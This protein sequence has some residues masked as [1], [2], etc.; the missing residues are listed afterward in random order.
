M[1]ALSADINA[2]DVGWIQVTLSGPAANDLTESQIEALLNVAPNLQQPPAGYLWRFKSDPPGK[3]RDLTLT[4]PSRAD[5]V[6]VPVY[7]ESKPIPS[8]YVGQ[9]A[10]AYLSQGIDNFT[11]KD[12]DAF[13]RQIV[14]GIRIAE[15]PIPE[16]LYKQWYEEAQAAANEH[17]YGPGTA[18]DAIR[19]FAEEAGA[20][21]LRQ[22]ELR[23]A[24]YRAYHTT[25]LTEMRRIL[26]DAIHEELKAE[27]GSGIVVIHGG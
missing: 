20:S 5:V 27:Q 16:N 11:L 1:T 25:D 18:A 26:Y 8:A 17:G 21:M 14:F 3:W 15:G 23:S 10:M 7:E 2:E 4:V 9:L 6:F 22:A 12:F 24:I 19:A 13:C